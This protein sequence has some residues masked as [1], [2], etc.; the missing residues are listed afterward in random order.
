M[1]FRISSII[2][3]LALF[4]PFEVLIL[5]YLPVSD[6]VYGYLRFAVEVVIYL[7]A[8]IMLMKYAFIV[9]SC[10]ICMGSYIQHN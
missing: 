9:R 7:V 2:F 3:L 4:V 8:G 1:K 6:S 10:C 5:K